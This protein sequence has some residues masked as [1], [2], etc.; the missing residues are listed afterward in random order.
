[1]TASILSE[2]EQGGI[3]FAAAY[4]STIIVLVLIAI[5]ILYVVTTRVLRGRGDVDLTLGA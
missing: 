3:S 5:G 1:M 2:W 4:A